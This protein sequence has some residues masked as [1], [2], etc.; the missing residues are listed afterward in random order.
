[1]RDLF[2]VSESSSGGCAVVAFAVFLVLLPV[3]AAALHNMPAYKLTPLAG[4]VLLTAVSDGAMDDDL[5]L[6]VRMR[7]ALCPPLQLP[8][9]LDGWKGDRTG[10]WEK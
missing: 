6:V 8:F 7:S 10:R 1:M 3:P 2:P 9:P 4:L 5:W